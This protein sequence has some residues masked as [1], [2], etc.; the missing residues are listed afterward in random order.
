LKW[1]NASVKLAAILI[2]LCLPCVATTRNYFIAAEE[3]SWDY[4]PSG[5]DLL[6]GNG[7]E[8]PWR[9]HTKWTKTRF[10]EYTDATFTERKP[11]PDWLG[12]LGPVIRAEVGDEIVVT[13]LNRTRAVHNIHPHGVRYDKASEGGYYLPI[14]AGSQ[15]PPNQRFTY[16]WFADQGSGPGPG[17]LTSVVW[18]YHPHVDEGSETNAG[19]MGPIIITAKGKA[20]PDG[21]PKDID[22]EFVA[23]FM[24]FDEAGGKPEGMFYAINGYVF[25]NLPGLTMKQGDKVR[26]YVMGMGNEK[27]IHTPHWHGKTV[28]DG[29]RNTDVIELLPASMVAVDM[30]ADNPGT[31]LFHCQVA[32]HMENGMTATYT[33]YK[34]PSRSC[35]VKFRDGDFWNPSGKSE[36]KF[37]NTSGKAI[38][39]I[40][41][42]HELVMGPQY[43]KK[44][45]DSDWSSGK[46]VPPGEGDTLEKPGMSPAIGKTVMGWAFYPNS[47]KFSDGTTWVPEDEGECFHVF[48]RDQDHPELLALPPRQVEMKED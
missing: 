39:R 32:D 18:W 29:R 38:S 25:G 47:I 34:P 27:D 31:W 13:F 41:I 5:Q 7:L 42:R 46:T 8:L 35:P 9:N 45:F 1:D 11:Q 21:T 23:T 19:L 30:I 36:L 37:D 15:V 4:A 26:W 17:E 3:V 12:I 44:P 24:M 14:G 43:V 22:K 40:V 2:L 33:I 20:R 28:T 16:H 10:I 48:W 6:H